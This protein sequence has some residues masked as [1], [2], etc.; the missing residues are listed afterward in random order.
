MWMATEIS[1]LPAAIRAEAIESIY[2]ADESWVMVLYE[3]WREAQDKDKEMTYLPQVMFYHARFSG[4]YEVGKQLGDYGL[5]YLKSD[6]ARKG[7]HKP[8]MPP[9]PPSKSQG[10]QNYEGQG[11][12]VSMCSASL[13]AIELKGLAALG[14]ALKILLE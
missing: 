7:Y 5:Q 2:G 9:K 12:Q 14:E 6:D 8:T 11:Q 10:L 1:T 13:I 3:L 4:N